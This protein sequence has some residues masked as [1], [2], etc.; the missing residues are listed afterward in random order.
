MDDC[1]QT[2]CNP[3]SPTPEGSEELLSKLRACSGPSVAAAD[4]LGKLAQQLRGSIDKRRK[5]AGLWS[6]EDL[7]PNDIAVLIQAAY[8]DGDLDEAYWRGFLAAHFGRCTSQIEDGTQD[9]AGQLLCGFGTE[10][11][12]TWQKVRHDETAFHK[13]LSS[14]TDPLKSLR[15]GNHRKYESQNPGNL[16]RVIKSFFAKVKHRGGS[17]ATLFKVDASE[18]GDAREKFSV[19]YWRLRGIKQFG[20]TGR[21][22]W[23]TFLADLNVLEVYPDS[24]YIK[25]STGPLKGAKRLWPGRPVKELEIL[26]N[27]LAECLKVSP[28]VVEDALCNWQK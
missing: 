26:A 8:K 22:D 27:N 19:L 6:S 13:W 25:G 12:W 4:G 3:S 11:K 18:A 5:A 9:S 14:Q 2:S 15:F 7:H 24:C 1:R 28:Q 20:R 17:P 21:F 16:W 23:L 10:P